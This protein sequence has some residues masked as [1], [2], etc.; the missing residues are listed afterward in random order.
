MRSTTARALIA[1]SMA[2]C[3]ELVPG[4]AS[5]QTAQGE[6]EGR[7]APVARR[8]CMGGAAAGALCNENADCPG[9]TCAAR[10]VFNIS[11]AVQFNATA[12][13]LTTIKNAISGMSAVLFDV[14]DGQ[15]EIGQATI[16][17]NAFGTAAD[18]RVYPTTTPTWWTTNTGG[19]K[20]GGSIHVSYNNIASAAAAGE[21][22]AHEFVHLV[23]DARDEYEARAA[24]CG[25]V[26]GNASCPDAG[27]VAAGQQACLMEVGGLNAGDP[28]TELCWGQGNAA[29][30]TDVSGGN[31]DATDV[32]EQ[33]RCRSNRSCWAQVVWSWPNTFLAPAGAPDPAA[34]GAIVDATKFI[35]VDATR[36]VVLV[37]DQS[38]SMSSE[39]PTRLERLKVAANDFVTLAE[40]GT[41]LGIVSFSTDA[42]PA[43][44]YAQVTIGALGANR[45]AWTNAVNALTPKARTNIG[46]GLQKARDL[47]TTA[48]GPTGNTFIV[49][50]TDG[51][52]NE[53][54]PNY[55]A[56]LQSKLNDLLA[57]GIPVY[58]T[59]TGSDLGLESQCSEIAAATNG[60]Y[61]DSADAAQL[62]EAFTDLHELTSRRAPITSLEGDLAKGE[63]SKTVPVEAGAQ[64]VT[65]ALTWREPRT[66]AD[67][68]VIDPAGAEHASSSMPMGRFARFNKPDAGA[69]TMVVRPP[70][71]TATEGN[72]RGTGPFVARA[73]VRH[74]LAEVRIAV[75]RPSVLPGQ[76]IYVYAF[77]GFSG[78]VSSN[79]PLVA[80]VLRPDGKEDRLELHDRGR[81]IGEAG[82]DEAEDGIFTGV[83]RA[84]SLSG[85]YSFVL[86]ATIDAWRRNAEAF[87]RDP[88]FRSPR[89]V[90]EVRASAAVSDPR[91]VTVDPPPPSTNWCRIIIAVLLLL[92]LIVALLWLRC[93]R[94]SATS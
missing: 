93:L 28:G 94:R 46:D 52:N 60:F 36:R 30:L 20:T 83:Y 15:A 10:N 25:M 90:R 42:D 40:T 59:C 6:I 7:A 78:P 58:V 9:S 33:S 12:A 88:K 56:D 17:N 26:T 31:H 65:F 92:L 44:G 53:P 82:D 35:D 55:A 68:V 24:G 51:L 79:Q 37:L 85:G 62:P 48:G 34:N 21:S 77:P 54:W 11:V 3:L 41:E 72:A 70:R 66:S 14:T 89:F 5:A 75:R 18:I 80:R 84:T 2:G 49:L 91:S 45:S 13:E 19:W 63:A 76:D 27:T 87:A 57:A 8:K 71:G 50:M 64:S 23:F 61:V 1:L 73:Y 69:W 47:I 43:H 67:L 32:T 4:R 29:N 74:Q 86:P 16:H 22:F 38:G 81:V 39:S